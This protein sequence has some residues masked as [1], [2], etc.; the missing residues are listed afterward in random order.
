MSVDSANPVLLFLVL[1]KSE[2]SEATHVLEML[3]VEFFT[4]CYQVRSHSI[5]LTV[6]GLLS[7]EIVDL[8]PQ[9]S[10]SA[11]SCTVASVPEGR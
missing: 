7:D 6:V 9:E 1:G 3:S 10:V 5:N 8:L 2:F 11:F 4:E